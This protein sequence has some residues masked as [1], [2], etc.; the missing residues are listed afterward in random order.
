MD[1]PVMMVRT[2]V[3][4]EGLS[5]S[6]GVNADTREREKESERVIYVIFYFRISIRLGLFACV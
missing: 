5:G 1:G 3:C 6:L 4:L 2:E